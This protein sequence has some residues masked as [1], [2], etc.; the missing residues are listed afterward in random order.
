M[1]D[2]TTTN[3][4]QTAVAQQQPQQKGDVTYNVAGQEVHLNYGIVR[5][6]LT[7]GGGDV[8]DAD[9]MQF[10]CI[11]KFNQ[12]NPFLNEAYLVKYGGAPATMIVSK[13][14]LMKRA[15]ACE[16]Y[17]GFEA[18]IITQGKDGAINERQ[19][20]FIMPG[21]TLVG[22]WAVVH[23]TDKK[24]PYVAKV[25]LQEYTTG[26]SLWTSKPSTMIRKVAIVQALREAFPAQLG[27]MYTQE[28]QAPEM[29]DGTA[30]EVK[31]EIRTKGNRKTI[32]METPSTTKTPLTPHVGGRKDSDTAS[33][34]RDP[35][36]TQSVRA[37]RQ[38]TRTDYVNT[39]TG[40]VIAHPTTDSAGPAY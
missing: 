17:D 40:E 37:V 30:V 25:S 3:Q 5:S 27:A 22:G 14:A 7:K 33:A 31:E 12:L 1:T 18:G 36:D 11:C 24:Y 26:K 4:N 16:G 29:I 35:V 6:F 2:M 10:I 20:C 32:S 23:R 13:E 38:G 34:M 9:L 19:G 15:E 21:E 28:E 39:E 8:S